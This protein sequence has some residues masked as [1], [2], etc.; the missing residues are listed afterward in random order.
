MATRQFS[1]TAA[2][3]EHDNTRQNSISAQDMPHLARVT[4]HIAEDAARAAAAERSMT[5]REGLKLYPRAVMWSVLISTC[6]VMEG[7]DIVLIN[8]LYGLPAFQQR[9]GVQLEDGTYQITAAWQSGLSNGA[10]V[11]EMIGLM[12]VGW[13]SEKFGYRKTMI[14]ALVLVAGFIFLLFFAQSLTMLLIGEIL[15]GIS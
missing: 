13:L 2:T 9:F 10:L 6:I 15:C 5:L 8:S 4:T 1:I 14:G 7:F 3:A 12:M 11:G